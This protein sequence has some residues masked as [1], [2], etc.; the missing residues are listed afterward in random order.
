[1][2]TFVEKITKSLSSNGVTYWM[3][4]E[5]LLEAVRGTGR[6]PPVVHLQVF[7]QDMSTVL[8]LG[9]KATRY[10]ALFSHQHG[11]VRV[12]AMR[13]VYDYVVRADTRRRYGQERYEF[14]FLFPLVKMPLGRLSLWAP[15]QAHEWLWR[16]FGTD[17]EYRVPETH[18]TSTRPH[19]TQTRFTTF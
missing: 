18:F 3:A 10:G 16:V 9:A 14:N 5:T 7:D 8:E 2:D 12:H 13:K 4:Y 6:V 19:P 1:M 11:Q 17:Y 15:R